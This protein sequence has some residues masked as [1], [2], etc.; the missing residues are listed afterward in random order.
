MAVA[1]SAAII[2]GVSAAGGIAKTI[3]GAKRAKAVKMAQARFK[4]QEMSNVNE[5][6]RISTRGADL[7]NEQNARG[8][9]TSADALRSG[10]VRG[11]VGGMQGLQEAANNNANQIGAG[12]DQQQVQLDRDFAQDEVRIQ[13]TK[14]QRDTA[15]LSTMQQQANAANQDIWSGIGDV[16][17]AVGGMAA[18]MG[19]PTRGLA[20]GKV[21]GAKTMG[22]VTGNALAGSNEIIAPLFTGR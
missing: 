12:L 11:V 15:E 10:G 18:G 9:A 6:R 8:M 22:A 19:D 2:A 5:G 3:S 20:G 17:G 4:R 1:T 7:A 16:A 21:L 14:E 13:N